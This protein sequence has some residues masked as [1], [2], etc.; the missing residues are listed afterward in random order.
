MRQ[1]LLLLLV[2]LPAG[3]LAQKAPSSP[4]PKAEKRPL[5]HEDVRRWRKIERPQITP[6]GQWVAYVLAPV[7]EGDATV[8]LWNAATGKT[9]AF[10]RGAEPQFSAD[11]RHF[12]FKIKPPLDTLK[13]QRRRKVKSEDLPRDSLA[14]YTLS[15]GWLWK[16][17]DV[18]SFAVPEKWSGWIAYRAEPMRESKTPKDTAAAAAP[19]PKKEDAKEN[20]SRLILRQLDT[21]WEDTLPYA[22]EYRFARRAPGLLAATSGRDTALRAGVYR[23]DFERRTWTPL[24]QADKGKFAQ[25]AL[26]EQGR[27]AAFLADLDTTRAT[28]RP[29]TL[30][31]W[32][33]GTP[34]ARP[35]ADTGSAFLP[36]APE[37]WGISEHTAVDFSEDGTMLYFGVAP[38]FPQPDTTLLPEE[39][40]QVEVW[41]HTQP[42]IYPEMAKRLEAE[43]KRGFPVVCH[44][45]SPAAVWPPPVRGFTVLGADLPEW[46]FQPQRNALRAL[47]MTEEPYA[48]LKQWEGEAPRDVYVV[49]LQTGERQPIVQGQRCRPYLSPEALHVV[50]WHFADTAWYGWSVETE[51]V[52]RLTDN[53]QVAFFNEKNDV[54]DYPNPY[55]L[56]T[57]LVGDEGVLLYDRYDLWLFDPG[58]QTA[59]QRLTRGRESRTVHRY[60]RL[61]PEERAVA[62][63][64]RLLLHV[65]REDTRDEGYAWLDL[66]TGKLTAWLSGP[67]R[68]S[69][70]PL[71][72]KEA[73]ALVFTKE[74]YHTFPDLLWTALPA[75]ASSRTPV[76]RRISE[77]NPQQKEY[78]WGSIELFRWL[79]PAG[80]TLQGLLVKPEGF[81]PKKQYPLM[82]N[83]YE[84]LSDELH[85]HR[86]P[87]YHRSQINYTMYA[88]RGY[89]VFAPDIPYRVGYPGQSAYDAVVS[90]VTALVE[91]GFI[92]ARRMGLQGHSWGGYQTAYIITRTNLFACAEAGAPVANM[93]SAYGGIRWES[94]L[95]RQFQYERQQS[96]I[97]GTLWE[98][99]MRYWENSP[100]F[101][102]DRV[103]TPLLIM[104]N[105]KDG[106]VP[107]AQ[108][109][110]LYTG[111]RRLGKPV[112]MLNYNDEPHWPVKLQNRADFQLRMQQFFDHYL[113]DAPKPRWMEEGIA[114]AEKGIRQGL[115]TLSPQ[116]H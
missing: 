61:D 78:R 40:V 25:L 104:H 98:Y 85:A 14:V 114:P 77:A 11:G 57:W 68:Y 45:E 115:E 88:S 7:T 112:W 105:D 6:D 19:K 8:C 34:T 87:D 54:P 31:Y 71:K 67:F 94:G 111:L 76:E 58:G 70:S 46:Q 86:A 16:T 20:G 5:Q 100:L 24:L 72:A 27:R 15:T 23:F 63:D 44:L 66:K 97:G 29:W 75:P 90:G 65:A 69:R 108:G 39:V 1:H 2:V 21:G 38:P 106:A 26:E 55:G 22:L 28:V 9:V 18:L 59:P 107:W 49:D 56:A 92:D 3:L 41:A 64:A 37:R 4:P 36:Q 17:P 91:R 33:D 82:V 109:I 74:N 81:D 89:V 101:F 102:L 10:E 110:E 30:Y 116:R 42:R 83:F 73:E 80:D 79:S 47:G 48:Y 13:A 103:Q 53:R 99:P 95:V 12:I 62:P 35:I 96:R 32:L 93:T 113:L 51:R 52:I 50:W 84:R 43:R 60:I